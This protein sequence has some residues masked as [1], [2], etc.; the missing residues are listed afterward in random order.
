MPTSVDGATSGDALMAAHGLQIGKRR[1]LHRHQL[2]IHPLELLGDDVETGFRHQ[3]MDV[4]DAPGDRVLDRH[5]GQRRLALAHRG[6][7][8]LEALAGQRLHLGIGGAAGEVGAVTRHRRG[9]I[10]L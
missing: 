4:G 8:V 1:A 6:E 2:V 3:V 9:H 5:H 7:H 10:R